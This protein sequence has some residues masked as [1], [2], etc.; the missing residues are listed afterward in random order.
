MKL[1]A[2]LAANKLL[3][4]RIHSTI[5]VTNFYKIRKR[6]QTVITISNNWREMFSVWFSEY[7]AFVLIKS[8]CRRN[9][10]NI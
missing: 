9:N 8:K 4:S 1:A 10:S 6:K 3:L 5:T 2:V 7:G